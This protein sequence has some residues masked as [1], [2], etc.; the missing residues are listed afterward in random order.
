[1]AM[2]LSGYV[3]QHLM[4][5]TMHSHV[6]RATR[7]HDQLPV[8]IKL[9]HESSARAHAAAQQELDMLRALDG[10]AVVRAVE[11]GYF[12][13]RPAVVMELF[14]GPGMDEWLD[15][16]LDLERFLQVA[17][18]IAT[19]V[20]TIHDRGVIHCDLKPSNILIDPETLAVCIADFGVAASLD[21][22]LSIQAAGLV[23]SLPYLSPE[24][25]GRTNISVDS[26]SDLY[27]LGATFYE[28]ITGR[29]PFEF[30]TPLELI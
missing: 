7:A 16:P 23:G 10:L 6:Y 22:M 12:E 26:R 28:L 30:A 25:T 5:E 17:I 27:S 9:D 11:L 4:C 19:A 13:D 24:R 20:A 18:A 2:Q 14:P 8:V 21:G 15:G 3:V 29:L 1:M